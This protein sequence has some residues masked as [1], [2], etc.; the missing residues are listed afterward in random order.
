MADEDV[1]GQARELMAM[2]KRRGFL[3]PAFDIYGG[4]AG[5]YDYGPLG[6][7][8]KRSFEDHWRQYY[9]V[10]EGFGEVSTPTVAPQEVFEAS[11]HLDQFDD[12]LVECPNCQAAVRADHF[13]EDEFDRLARETREATDALLDELSGEDEKQLRKARELVLDEIA[14]NRTRAEHEPGA[15]EIRELLCV[16]DDPAP[17]ESRHG[18][19]AVELLSSAYRIVDTEADE[20]LAANAVRCKACDEELHERA[21][22]GPFNLMFGTRIG[23][24]DGD[25]G[26]LR[27][28]TAQG[29]FLN[30][31]WLYRYER[32]Q[33]PFGAVQIGRAYRNEI[34]PRQGLVR[35]REFWQAEAEVFVDPDDK[36]HPEFA[37]V[38]DRQVDLVPAE[39][40]DRT[41]S[42]AK[43]VEEGVIANEQVAYYVGRTQ[44]LL[45]EAGVD[46]DKLRFRQHESDEMA[47]YATDCWDA[48]FES[49]RY[50]WVECVGIADRG[51]YD[52]ESHEEKSGERLKVFRRFDEPVEEDVTRIEPLMSVLGPEFGG[53]A[54][55]IAEALRESDPDDLDLD[56][57]LEIAVDGD[58]VTVPADAYDLVEETNRRE[59]EWVYPHVIEPSYGMDRILYAV[60]EH[61]WDTSGERNALSLPTHMAPVE[62][63]VLPLVSKDGLPQKAREIERELKRRGLVTKY[64][65][66]GSIGRRYARLDEIGTPFAVTIDHETL[67]EGTVTVRHRDTHDQVRVGADR[68]ADELEKI[69]EGWQTWD[70]LG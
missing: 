62:V 35:L 53:Q 59:G 39:H 28:E 36:T 63:G 65:D 56:G 49:I 18:R 34:S 11:G 26:F 27:P 44:R 3:K 1:P 54:K 23:P 19:Y 7:G 60:L 50:G 25:R 13:L 14:N 51:C 21:E 6:Q 46:R 37:L 17:R 9:V 32:E 29:L 61:N 33:V 58:T 24:G 10:E 42:L 66:G 70:E 67:E 64:D 52:L 30:E 45:V 57:A 68:V 2:L 22:I 20:V 41:C 38:A 69:A 8:L 4:V 31:D 43:A 48:E 40:E 5:F 55:P 47:H 16:T 12:T 15:D